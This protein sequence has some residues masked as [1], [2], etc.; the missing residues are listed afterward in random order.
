[1]IVI[2]I[3]LQPLGVAE[4][5][6][7]LGELHIINDGTGTRNV[8]HYRVIVKG[9]NGRTIREARVSDWPRLSRPVFELILACLTAAGYNQRKQDVPHASP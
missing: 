3:E 1:M 7:P 9:A 6:R 5:K 2:P 8:G 4:H